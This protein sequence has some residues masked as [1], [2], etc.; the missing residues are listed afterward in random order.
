MP[1]L[2]VG[3]VMEREAQAQARKDDWRSV[4]EDCYEFALPQRNLYSGYYEG[5]VSGKNKMARVFDS[6][7]IHATQRFA[8]RIQAGL[9]PPYKTWCRL[10]TGS[11]IPQQNEAQA[12]S[13]LDQYTTTMSETLRQ[14]NF[15]LAMGEFLLDLAVGTAVMMIMPG[16]EATPIRFAP[17]PQYLVA[18]EEGAF[19]N[20]DNVYRKLRLK[21]EAIPVEY[22]DVKR[23]QE[24]DDMIN[25]HPSRVVDL[26]DAI[27][28]D[29]ESG[30][31]HYYV[32]WPG[33]KQELVYRE[34]R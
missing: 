20:V 3:Q 14:T 6:T 5:G 16:D 7:A 1:K 32:I 33:K 25:N 23:S 22:P 2:E 34:M 30:R 29:P 21:A 24:L 17:I 13:V 4:Y 9:F 8:N 31:Y 26:I 15:D 10:E 12:Q 18:I 28:F 11:A 27:I 19:G